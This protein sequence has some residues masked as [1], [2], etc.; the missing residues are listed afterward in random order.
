MWSL[1][2]C[3]LLCETIFARSLRSPKKQK[4]L[5]MRHTTRSR[6][7]ST[8]IPISSGENSGVWVFDAA[9]AGESVGE[10]VGNGHC[11]P[12]KVGQVMQSQGVFFIFEH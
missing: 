8:A 3:A 2:A 10:G 12:L 4:M 11:F 5:K 9:L 7:M 1:V 6:T